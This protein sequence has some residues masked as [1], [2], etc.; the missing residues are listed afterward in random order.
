MG[1]HCLLCSSGLTSQALLFHCDIRTVLC[2]RELHR[3]TNSTPGTVPGAR[4]TV[5]QSQEFIAKEYT[6]SGH[7]ECGMLIL[8]VNFPAQGLPDHHLWIC[9]MSRLL[10]HHIH[11]R[12][13][14]SLEDTRFSQP[15]RNRFWCQSP[16]VRPLCLVHLRVLVHLSNISCVMSHVLKMLAFS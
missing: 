7:V 1:C 14:F 9:E 3:H 2:S 4:N 12:Q 6:Y 8:S 16:Q 15:H 5:G 13:S 11:L 10:S